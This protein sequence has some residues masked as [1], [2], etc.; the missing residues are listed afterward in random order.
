MTKQ[1]IERLPERIR[2]QIEMLRKEYANRA[3]SKDATRARIGGYADGLRDAGLI[4][5]HER[6]VLIVYCM[7]VGYDKKEVSA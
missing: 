4:N 3:I 5:N 6:G 1:L 2:F 7:T